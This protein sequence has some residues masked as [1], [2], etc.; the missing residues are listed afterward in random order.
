[1]IQSTHLLLTALLT[2]LLLADVFLEFNA[3]SFSVVL[4]GGSL[5]NCTINPPEGLQSYSFVFSLRAN[6]WKGHQETKLVNVDNG[7]GCWL[8]HGGSCI[9]VYKISIKFFLKRQSLKMIGPDQTT[10]W[11]LIQAQESGRLEIRSHLCHFLT[12][13][14]HD[15]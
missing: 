6:C 15:I 8:V 4:C 5:H 9:Y 12:V 14:G 7:W 1:M 13:I 10:E 3:S 11:K 2:A